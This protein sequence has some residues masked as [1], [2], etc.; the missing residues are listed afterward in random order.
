[1]AGII[2]VNSSNDEV[3]KIKVKPEYSTVTGGSYVTNA[4]SLGGESIFAQRTGSVLEFKGLVAGNNITLLS[5]TS[6]VTINSIGGGDTGETITYTSNNGI[7][8]S[9]N[10]NFYLGGILT[11]NTEINSNALEFNIGN[12]GTSYLNFTSGAVA[13]ATDFVVFQLTD[14]NGGGAVYTDNQGNETGIRYGGNYSNTFEKFSLVDKN[15]VTGITST[16]AT[17]EYVNDITSTLGSI[18]GATNGLTSENN[19]IRLGGALTQDTILTGSNTHSIFFGQAG[20]E[21]LST[22]NI[23]TTGGYSEWNAGEGIIGLISISTI[24]EGAGALTILPYGVQLNGGNGTNGLTI[25]DNGFTGGASVGEVVLTGEQV[26]IKLNVVNSTP[27]LTSI[28]ITPAET[29]TIVID[30]TNAAF[31]GVKYGQDFSSNFVNG[32]LINK[33]FA[34]ATYKSKT[35]NTSWETS[36]TTTLTDDVE[37]NGGGN[38]LVYKNARVG[39]EATGNNPAF[40]IGGR[41]SDPSPAYEGD[42]Y[43]NTSTKKFK[44]YNGTIWVDFH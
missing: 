32:S 37:I 31:E 30:S 4:V 16:L 27:E 2:Y 25:T 40:L 12:L 13:L 34:D 26:P 41:G 44:G 39:F 5:T 21:E 35:D 11:G 22:F 14:G 10:N 7:T 33:G 23:Y 24:G 1:M 8:K 42:V 38:I 15:Y 28:E 20:G 9:I 36:G 43:F 17:I 6:G 3:I 18:S 19:V 29:P